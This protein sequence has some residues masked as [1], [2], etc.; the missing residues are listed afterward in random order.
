M[1]RTITL[2]V[3]ITIRPFTR[4]EIEDEGCDWEEYKEDRDGDVEELSA[5]D[6]ADLVS[7]HIRDGA[8]E[9]LVGSDMLVAISRVKSKVISER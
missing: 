9:M 2:E 7:D 1:Q 8:T 5:G 4:E 6:L 3:A